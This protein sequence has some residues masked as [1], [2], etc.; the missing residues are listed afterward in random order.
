MNKNGFTTVE[1]VLTMVLVIVIMSTITTV[2]L[3]YRDKSDYEEIL[4]NT[5]NYK[6]TVT[7]II[8]DDILDETNPVT[9]ITYNET[10]N[11]Y[12]F[13]RVTDSIN[14]SVIESNSSPNKVAIKYND[15][16]GVDTLYCKDGEAY[17][18]TE[19]LAGEEPQNVQ[20]V[21]L[22][23]EETE[24][25]LANMQYAYYYATA[26][27]GVD[28]ADEVLNYAR[29]LENY[30]LENFGFIVNDSESG[31]TLTVNKTV[32][33]DDVTFNILDSE[34]LVDGTTKEVVVVFENNQ[35]KSVTST[36]TQY[37]DNEPVETWTYSA[38]AISTIEFPD[39]SEFLEDS[40]A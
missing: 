4:A 3:V 34:S 24:S 40:N 12:T 25:T 22:N 15:A 11:Q 20:K 28:G 2:T 39:F 33:E 10:S 35:L 14:L 16:G 36:N 21:K 19:S 18:Q 6:N 29:N 7:K 32:F 1:M 17:K 37:V 31:H 9:A 5:I 38:T 26:P 23:S 13:Q 8:Y 27:V 30:L